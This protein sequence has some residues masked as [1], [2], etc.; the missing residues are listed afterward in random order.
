[1]RVASVSVPVLQL[2]AADE[3]RECKWQDEGLMAMVVLQDLWPID[4][5]K[6]TALEGLS[7]WRAPSKQ[8][9]KRTVV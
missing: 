6:F 1:M 5:I 7:P 9:N 3:S 8:H 4:I 2:V